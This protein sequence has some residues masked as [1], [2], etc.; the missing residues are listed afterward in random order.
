MSDVVLTAILILISAAIGAALCGP[1]SRATHAPTAGADG[2]RPPCPAVGIGTVRAVDGPVVI[3][4]ESISGQR[5]VGRLRQ[6]SNDSPDAALRPGVVLL[7]TFDPAA[8]EQLSLADDM[9]AV[10]S[11]FDQM[12]VRKG[13]VT[14]EQLDLIRNG[15]RARGV[16]TA[17]RATGAARED[18]REVELDLMV[19]RP[20]GGQFPA[21]EIALVPESAM[22]GVGPGSVIDAYYRSDDES[23]VAV[24]VPPG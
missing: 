18:Y 4:V 6:R 8:R 10:R 5:F 19:R 20:A 15:T 1:L 22:A 12:L 7:V 14:P 9:I 24:C 21:H 13:L 16:V 23:S 11:A 2:R 3:D 17:M